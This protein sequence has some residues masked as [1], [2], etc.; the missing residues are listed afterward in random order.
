MGYNVTILRTEQGRQIPI[1]LDEAVTAAQ[2]MEGWNYIESPLTLEYQLKERTCTQ[3]YPKRTGE[4]WTKS[5]EEGELE[6]MLALAK[7]LNAR[8]RGDEWETYKTAKIADL[9][10]DDVHL[11]KEAEVQGKALIE[12][13]LREQK[14]IRKAIIGFF[15]VLSVIGY[16]CFN[17][18][19]GETGRSSAI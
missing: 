18:D 19:L 6:V 1:T 4:L 17:F 2:D 15:F 13:S 8:V 12:R 16:L 3:R 9:H 10:P 14:F 7:R 5:P 11:R